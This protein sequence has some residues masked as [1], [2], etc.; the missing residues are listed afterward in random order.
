MDC[1]NSFP[2]WL[3]GGRGSVFTETTMQPPSSPMAPLVA[4]RRFRSHFSGTAADGVF[5]QDIFVGWQD[6]L[7][8]IRVMQS[9]KGG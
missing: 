7:E 6:S 5:N 4:P 3:P 2:R 1:W 9:T 8:A